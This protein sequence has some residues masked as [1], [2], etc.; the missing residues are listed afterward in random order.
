MQKDFLT[1]AEDFGVNIG[2]YSQVNEIMKFLCTRGEGRS[3]KT[4]PIIIFSFLDQE[5]RANCA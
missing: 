1:I 4:C 5:I 2:I 3:F